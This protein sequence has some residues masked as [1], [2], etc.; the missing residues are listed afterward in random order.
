[1]VRGSWIDA[2]PIGESTLL[3]AGIAIKEDW[4]RRGTENALRS[5]VGSAWWKVAT[6]EA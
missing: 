3:W 6:N 2:K 5:K 1:M 4:N